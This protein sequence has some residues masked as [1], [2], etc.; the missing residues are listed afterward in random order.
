MRTSNALA[1]TEC[2]SL[3]RLVWVVPL[4][5]AV[6]PTANIILYTII[7]RWFQIDLL[8]GGE[9]A[10][11]WWQPPVG[12]SETVV[13]QLPVSD[14]ILFSVVFASAAGIVFVIVSQLAQ[15][16]IR[17]YLKIATVALFLS[18]IPPLLAPSPPVAMTVKLSLVAMHIVG[19]I[20]VV[21][22]LIGL[23]RKSYRGCIRDGRFF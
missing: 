18:F 5:T 2:V 11:F 10:E 22:V 15:R 8:I 14:I 19:A 16:P 7:T 17:T 6:A 20:A 4:A 9:E 23:G 3:G 1:E 13:W 21:G 12:S